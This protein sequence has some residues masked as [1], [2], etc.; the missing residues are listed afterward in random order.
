LDDLV[1]CG[2]R[3]G[4]SSLLIPPRYALAADLRDKRGIGVAQIDE[5]DIV[6]DQALLNVGFEL[7]KEGEG[8]FAAREYRDVD[9]AMLSRLAT[10]ARAEQ[11]YPGVVLA[12]RI[13]HQAPQFFD[14]RLLVAFTALLG[15]FD[16]SC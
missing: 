16:L 7:A 9:V 10:G 5:I 13:E 3:L 6:G 15:G 2:L 4:E 1:Q 11:P 12:E 8:K 14:R